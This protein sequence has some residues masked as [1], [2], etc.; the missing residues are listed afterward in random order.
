MIDI[1]KIKYFYYLVVPMTIWMVSTPINA[2]AGRGARRAAEA[3]KSAACDDGNGGSWITGILFFG[4]LLIFAF[5]WNWLEER[6]LLHYSETG[7]KRSTLKEYYKTERT[8]GYTGTF[9]EFVLKFA[10]E[11]EDRLKQFTEH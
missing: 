6:E 5:I 2:W 3:C 11:R 10:K 1:I 9:G 7:T 8:K 4:G